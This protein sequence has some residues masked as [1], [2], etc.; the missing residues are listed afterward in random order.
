MISN[1]VITQV[2]EILLKHPEV[3]FAYVHGSVLTSETPRDLDIAIFLHPESYKELA[4][5]GEASIGFA[6]PLEMEL[7]RAL[8]TKADIQIL[9]TAPLSFRHRI[10]HDGLLVI[11]NEIDM[12]CHFEYLS[13]VQYFDFRPR[14]EQYLREVIS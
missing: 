11:D 9:N 6:I 3:S 10:V 14:R 2:Q 7:E 12:R 4:D 5:K 13:R 1:E 8:G